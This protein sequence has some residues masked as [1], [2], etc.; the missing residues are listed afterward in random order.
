M[1]NYTLIKHKNRTDA[2]IGISCLLFISLNSLPLPWTISLSSF[3]ME[4]KKK[5]IITVPDT[6]N[7]CKCL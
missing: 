1:V 6:C 3:I 7:V 4:E 5:V 2:S